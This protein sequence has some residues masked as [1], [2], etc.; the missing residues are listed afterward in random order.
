MMTPQEH[1]KAF[2]SRCAAEM[3]PIINLRGK[4][5][6]I[7]P[8]EIGMQQFLVSLDLRDNQIQ[9]LPPALGLC[10]NLIDLRLEGNPL[11]SPPPE[12]VAQGI[13]AIRSYLVGRLA[14]SEAQ[15]RCKLILVG[16]GGVGK[17]SLLR[18]LMGETFHTDLETTH[19]ITIIQTIK[20]IQSV[21]SCPMR[22]DCMIAMAM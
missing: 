18:N 20:S 12:I 2:L 15:W 19:G 8:D 9:S 4:N 16:E 6:S 1:L 21:R 10:E 11:L 22:G 5:I 3:Q 14:G 7:L 13:T 17:T